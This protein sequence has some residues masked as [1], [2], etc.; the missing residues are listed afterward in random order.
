MSPK[1]VDRNTL[2]EP[3]IGEYEAFVGPA[4]RP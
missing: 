1:T 3:V 4:A 2:P